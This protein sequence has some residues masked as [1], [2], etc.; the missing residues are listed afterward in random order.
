M[1]RNIAFLLLLIFTTSLFYGCTTGE[2]VS[3]GYDPLPYVYFFTPDKE[4]TVSSSAETISATLNNLSENNV[5]TGASFFV[6][7]DEDGYADTIYEGKAERFVLSPGTEKEIT[8]S[9]RGAALE[10]GNNYRITLN[11]SYTAAG[12]DEIQGAV[13]FFFRCIDSGSAENPNVPRDILTAPVN[14]LTE[15]EQKQLAQYL[16]EV[17]IPCSYGIFEDVSGLSSPSLWS[18]VE[19][20]NAAVDH[21]TSAASHTLKA[22]QEKVNVYYPGASFDPAK[23]RTYDPETETFLSSGQIVSE[24]YVFLSYTV[25]GNAISVLYEDIPDVD[26]EEPLRYRTTLTNSETEGYF[27]FLSSVRIGAIG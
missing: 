13:S 8:F 15:S 19:A 24:E 12:G 7:R 6:F 25:E 23:V 18:S 27:S 10:S 4:R 26:G 9:L 2:S 16:F 20:L 22:V 1:K 11:V 5:T 21:D 17:Y 3:D 14:T